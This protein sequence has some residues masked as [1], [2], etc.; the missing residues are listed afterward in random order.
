MEGSPFL[1]LPEGMLIDQVQIT[2]TG[3]RLASGTVVSSRAL[4]QNETI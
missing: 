2:E 1:P 4:P 3:L